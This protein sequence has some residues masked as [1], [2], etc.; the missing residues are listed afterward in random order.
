LRD[1]K[2]PTGA[3]ILERTI[4]SVN[5]NLDSCGCL[6]LDKSGAWMDPVDDETRAKIK[7]KLPNI[8]SEA[9]KLR[10]LQTAVAAVQEEMPNGL[11][12][13]FIN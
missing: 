9:G 7:V 3:E 10:R 2:A 12:V 4:A 5:K 8:I 1:Y 6:V 11:E 13:E